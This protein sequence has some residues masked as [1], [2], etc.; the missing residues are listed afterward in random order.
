MMV[1]LDASGLTNPV[2][3]SIT[4]VMC[5]Y[6][7]KRFLQEQLD[8]IAQ[9]T[10]QNWKLLVSDD[11]SSDQT[12]ELIQ[13]F[14]DRYPAGK[15]LVFQGPKS[16]F[17]KNFLSALSRPQ[18][19]TPYIAFAD[20]DDVW[21]SDKLERA[22][23]TL[24]SLDQQ[25]PLLYASR[26]CFVDEHNDVLG[27]STLF[28]KA[29]SFYNALVQS[30]GGGNTMLFNQAALRLVLR[31]TNGAAIISHDWWL[32]ILVSAF[33]GVTV[34]DPRP[35][36]LYR[37]HGNNLMGMN[38]GLRQKWHRIRLLLAGDFR[39]WNECHIAILSQYRDSMSKDALV[40]FDAF[41][42]ARKCRLF[43]RLFWMYRSGVYRQTFLGNLGIFFATLTNRI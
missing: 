17:A 43:G 21:L 4:I 14:S 41:V 27:K 28:S 19:D 30:I 18:L 15:V 6:N 13:Q 22:F 9:Q 8:S 34:Y 20:Q 38:T 26:T 2:E 42:K 3:A 33:S 29:P 36:V 1:T 32:Y 24:E 23:N 10:F 35:T 16:G 11:G 31:Y 39:K 5:T 12:L 40:V 7:G 25:E 37:Q